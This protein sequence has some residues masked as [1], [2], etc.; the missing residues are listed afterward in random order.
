MKPVLLHKNEDAN[1]TRSPAVLGPPCLEDTS[2][3]IIGT[4][5]GSQRRMGKVAT[6]PK[7]YQGPQ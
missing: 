4:A 5:L 3:H 7:L 1:D 6:E 2:G